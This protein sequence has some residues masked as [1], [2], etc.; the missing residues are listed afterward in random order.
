MVLYPVSSDS[1]FGNLQLLA[2]LGYLGGKRR[3]RVLGC[4]HLL[5][6]LNIAV[7]IDMRIDDG[8]GAFGCQSAVGNVYR[9][10]APVCFDHQKTGV[11][12]NGRVYIRLRWR[13]GIRG[14]GNR[15]W[16]AG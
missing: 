12:V 3:I 11:S 6:Y 2:K 16:L 4:C 10:R 9:H 5:L 7:A 15:N 1:R 8:G 13:T 14:L